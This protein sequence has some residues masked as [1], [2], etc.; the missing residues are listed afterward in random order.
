MWYKWIEVFNVIDIK[1]ALGNLKACKSDGLLGTNSN[2]FKYAPPRFVILL[3]MLIRMM[4]IHGHSPESLLYS[5]IISIPKCK[6]KSLSDS[7]NYR[8]IALC[9]SLNKLIDLLILNKCGSSLCSSDY[10]FGFKR[11]QSTTLCTSVAQEVIHYYNHKGS[12]IYACTL[13][14]SKAFDKVNFGRLFNILVKSDIPAI[15]V[16]YIFVNYINQHMYIKWDNCLSQKIFPTNGVKQGGVLSPILFNMY[17][18]ILLKRFNNA[19]I[20]CK[21]GMSSIGALAYADDIILLC[22]SINSLKK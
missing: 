3:T 8:G 14:T 2:H 13:D 11:G 16:R 9:Y 1:K 15:V 22:P 4:F 6:R 19:D 5:I 21:M 10:Q 20:G 17:I 7:N 12:N 18:D